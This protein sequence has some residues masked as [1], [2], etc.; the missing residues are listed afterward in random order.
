MHKV[1]R[2]EPAA[3]A[4]SPSVCPEV[5]YVSRIAS[6]LAKKKKK[7]AKIK[8]S[9]MPRRGVSSESQRQTRKTLS[10]ERTS[11]IGG[12]ASLLANSFHETLTNE[13]YK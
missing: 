1:T 4:S 7:D 5:L 8:N 11:L 12:R 13:K 2:R 10:S 3:S 9:T 6:S